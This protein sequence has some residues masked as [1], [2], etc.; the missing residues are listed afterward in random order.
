MC[1]FIPSRSVE[2]EINTWSLMKA[3]LKTLNKDTD[4][5]L[6]SFLK[7]CKFPLQ[8][9]GLELTSSKAQEKSTKLV[10]L[11]SFNKSSEMSDTLA[12]ARHFLQDYL[13]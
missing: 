12:M 1:S 4:I 3:L 9:F 8:S 2:L 7:L 13:R 6:T 5:F 10:L 11:I